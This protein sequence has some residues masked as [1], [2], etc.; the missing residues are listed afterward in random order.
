MHVKR[1]YR[2]TVREAL[3]AA[4]DELGPGAL[5]LSTELVPRRRLEGLVGATRGPSD[6]GGRT[7]STGDAE[8]ERAA[9]PERDLSVARSDVTARRHRSPLSHIRTGVDG[10]PRGHRHGSGPGRGGRRPDDGRGVSRRHPMSGCGARSRL[11]SNLFQV[12][13]PTT[14]AARCSWDRRAWA[15]P[16]RSPR[17]PHR[18]ASARIAP[19]TSCPPTGSARVP[20]NSCAA[21]PKSWPCRSASARTA[22]DLARR[23]VGGA[24]SHSRRHGW[25]VDVGGRGHGA[26]RGAV[27]DA[28]RAHASGDGRRH[29]TGRRRARHPTVRD[30]SS[31]LESVITKIDE[32]ES[33]M[34][35]LGVVRDHGLPV[36]YLTAGQRV[37]EDLCRA[38]PASLAAL[39]LREPAMEDH[40]C[41]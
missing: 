15:R 5:V 4:R 22:D 35:L 32:A 10:P 27:P 12:R 23:P 38:T 33:L 1:I 20:S 30:G 28:Q 21:T 31:P 40:L 34:P 25:P 16:R 24:Q 41:H 2:P 26:R 6:G 19:S 13:P 11:N 8:P 39:L 7:A 3:A 36:S 29:A 18:N 17:L 14:N 9:A 37:P